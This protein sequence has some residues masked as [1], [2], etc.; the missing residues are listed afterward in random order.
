MKKKKQIHSEE[1]EH[2]GVSEPVLCDTVMVDACHYTCV[3]RHRMNT[4]EREPECK[5]WSS[6]APLMCL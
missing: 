6:G 5:L 3:Q 1:A 2:F 4:T